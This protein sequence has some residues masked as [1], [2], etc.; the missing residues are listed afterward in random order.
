VRR[1]PACNADAPICPKIKQIRTA[2]RMP[3][4]LAQGTK[5]CKAGARQVQVRVQVRQRIASGNA[6]AILPHAS[7]CGGV[8]VRLRRQ[9][10]DVPH[11]TIT[12]SRTGTTGLATAPI[13][14]R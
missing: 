5:R 14:N 1:Y 12:A 6:L 4:P 13:S 7:H 9:P 11:T 2:G 8:H 3:R 10:A